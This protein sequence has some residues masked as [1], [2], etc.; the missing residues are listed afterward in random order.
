M[1]IHKEYNNFELTK[2]IGT[3]DVLKANVIIHYF[4]QNPK[5]HPIIPIF[6]LLYSYFS[7]VVLI[8]KAELLPESQ[9]ASMLG[10]HPYAL[11]EYVQ[12]ARN[13]KLGKVIDVFKYLKEADLRFK[14]VDAGSMG[15]G[16]ILR[17]LVYKIVH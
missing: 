9:L 2:A 8:H 10:I 1:G 14:G 7:K 16:E 6:S 13:Y 3:R 11:K 17:E 4:I 15:E 5:N 12:A